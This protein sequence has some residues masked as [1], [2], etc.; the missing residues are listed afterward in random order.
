MPRGVI[1]IEGMQS[2][3]ARALA[4]K[5]PPADLPFDI[6]KIGHVVLKVADLERA[7][8]F[9][10]Q[11][12]GFA[13]SDVYPGTMMPGG[14]VFLR[15]N[16]DHHGLALVG[17]AEGPARGAELH[18]MAFEVATLDEVLRARGHLAKHGVEIIFEGRRRAGAQIAL[19]FRDPDGHL[20]EIY[21]GLDQ[22]GPGE[23]AR[24][25]GQWREAFSLEEAID[26]P[27]AG[28]DTSLRD[29]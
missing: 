12:M 13:V 2:A 19:E 11:V 5:A 22:I 29:H 27:P 7:V 3:Q 14:M 23:Q 28:Q 4:D 1:D 20:L 21:W 25:P 8:D 10:T 26:N 24:P 18:H 6:K 17:G 15:C 16:R 9:Y